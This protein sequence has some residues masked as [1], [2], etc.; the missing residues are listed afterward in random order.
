MKLGATR[1]GLLRKAFLRNGEY[2]DQGLWS[3]VAADWRES[4]RTRDITRH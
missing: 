4:M 2:H 1:D 3:V